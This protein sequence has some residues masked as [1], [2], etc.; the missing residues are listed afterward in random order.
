M[1]QG[2]YIYVSTRVEVQRISDTPPHHL[3]EK[4]L[5]P[6]GTKTERETPGHPGKEC[7]KVPAH[8]TVKT[9]FKVRYDILGQYTGNRLRA[10]LLMDGFSSRYFLS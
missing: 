10:N 4:P 3:P 9:Q 7:I 6:I 1:G 8:L 5:N 2:T